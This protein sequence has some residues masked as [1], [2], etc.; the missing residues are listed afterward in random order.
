MARVGCCR[1]QE[2]NGRDKRSWE[3]GNTSLVPSPP[4]PAFFS[5]FTHVVHMRKKLGVETGNEAMKYKSAEETKEV[6]KQ[7]CGYV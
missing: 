4:L 5:M 3:V 7:A 6:C 1:F 2:Y